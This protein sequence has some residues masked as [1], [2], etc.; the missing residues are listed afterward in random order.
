MLH[1]DDKG[2]MGSNGTSWRALDE[3]WTLRLLQG[4]RQ[5]PPPLD[6]VEVP[7]R[8]PGV[9]H[10]DLYAAG[11][12]GHHDVRLAENDQHWVGESAWGY[13]TT[14]AWDGDANAHHD[15]V[16]Q[17]LDTLAEVTCNGVT[18]GRTRNM[19]RTHRFS[20]T[21]I[22]TQGHNT[23]T[24]RFDPIEE[25]IE[26]VIA[27][28]GPLPSSHPAGYAAVRKMACNFGWD[29][30]PRLVTAGIWKPIGVQ[31]WPVAR[32]GEVRPIARCQGTDGRLEIAA[33]VVGD[34]ET[35]ELTMRATV[36]GRQAEIEVD[37]GVTRLDVSVP[38]ARR[39][40][41]VGLGEPTLYDVRVDLLLGAEVLDRWQGRIGFRTVEVDEAPDADGSRWAL[42]VNDRVVFVRGFN[43]IPDRPFPSS[44]N[45]ARYD[46]RLRQAL[47]ANANL[48]RVWGGGIYESVDFYRTSDELGLMVWQD[49]LFACAA[50]PEIP[51]VAAEIEAEAHEAIAERVSHP[52]LV[53][54]NG[55]NECVWGYHDWGW[56]EVLQGRPWGAAYYTE[57]LPALVAKLDPV[58]PYL[59]ASPW[60]G[61]LDTAPNTDARGVSH[62]WDVWNERDYLDYRTHRPGFVAEMGWCGPPTWATLRRAVPEGPLGPDNPVLRHHQRAVNGMHKL[63]RGLREH[64]PAVSRDD[65]WLFLLQITQA[66]ALQVGLEHLRTVER[67]A[68]AIVW[69]L[70]DC[71]PVISW[72]AVDGDQRPKPLWYAI[73][74]AF[75]PCRATLQ[76]HD[77]SLSLAVVNDSAAC[78][79][80]VV[81][82]RRVA[83]D[84]EVR[85]QATF[86]PS[87]A[88][89]TRTWMALPRSL[90]IPQ[91]GREE[92]LVA[93][94]PGQRS[95]W[96]WQ[97]DRDLNY[98]RAVFEARL[99]LGTGSVMV[100]ARTL[101]RDL[102]L[103]PDRVMPPAGAGT[104]TAPEAD[105]AVVTL[106]PGE[107]HEFRLSKAVSPAA[108]EALTCQ[109][110]L[111][112]VNDMPEVASR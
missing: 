66:R 103:F 99:D 17:G 43:W 14:F 30:G 74:T 46:R 23:L 69:Q 41:P 107:T 52:S 109:P 84:G 89:G 7:A 24:V 54:W 111:R 61:D 102:C 6:R 59:P 9:V 110:A 34:H 73:R 97:R 20:L 83:F 88:P 92:L 62:L 58:T 96:F 65:D 93:D 29:W 51:Y 1:T 79:N 85:A 27:A 44:V 56:K 76:P 16:C 37:E 48:V 55:N 64:F 87:T 63:E 5:H 15:L 90:A 91:D 50:Y 31:S 4:G 106:L 38:N 33:T 3:G 49:F 21:G 47:D 100:I 94:T 112:C 86:T 60:S 40:W 78:W 32:L 105:T 8:V 36:D 22:L 72:A 71:W 104:A 42:R 53:L 26:R 70:N 45:R 67:C 68:G 77:D 28:V 101:L 95:T 25:E 11:V 19:H 12:I 13:S 35:R 82:V 80:P 57:L 98:P 75:S 10:T 81:E 108:A 39:W 18:L 2:S